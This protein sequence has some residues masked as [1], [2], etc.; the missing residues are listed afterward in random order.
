MAL[1]AVG[2]ATVLAA[3]GAAGPAGGDAP[4][5]GAAPDSATPDTGTGAG[6]PGTEPGG[7]LTVF[8]AASLHDAY[9]EVAAAVERDHPQV[10]V[11]LSFAGSS[12]LVAQVLAGAPADVLATADEA[13]MRRAVD[14]GAVAGEPIVVAENHLALVV[15]AGNPARVT[16]LDASLDEAALVVCAPQVPC[17]AAAQQLAALEGVTLRPVSEESAVTDVLDKVTSGQADAGLVYSTDAAGTDAVE[18]I[19]VPGA[20]RV[21]N[22]YP[23]AVVAGAHDPALAALWVR[24]LTGEQGRAI[25]ADAGFTLP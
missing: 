3:C 18:T 11:S 15:P 9:E 24:T 20:D 8:A 4:A 13:T 10:E 7:E 17:G 1:A 25:L 5:G 22:R 14:G 2:L 12:D 21:V 23:V 6:T 19:A 16:G